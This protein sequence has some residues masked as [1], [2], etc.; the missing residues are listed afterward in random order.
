MIAMPQPSLT[1]GT[2]I[3]QLASS[4]ASRRASLTWPWKV[5]RSLTPSASA[6]ATS[7]ADHQ[8]EPITS[9]RRSGMAGCS[10]ASS[11]Q[12]VL[13]LLVR[14]QP[15]QHADPRGGRARLQPGRVRHVD[16]VADHRDPV[17]VDAEAGQVVPAGLRD[18]DV[19]LPAVEPGRQP[20]LHPPAD[21]AAHAG[22]DDLPLLA[23][24]VVHQH[25][26]V[27]AVHQRR[28][29]RDA[30]VDVDDD[31][32]APAGPAEQVG[33]A[34]G[35]RRRAGRP[36]GGTGRRRAPRRPGRWGARR[37]RWSPDGRGRPA[38]GPCARRRPPNRR[39]RGGGVAPHQEGDA[40]WRR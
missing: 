2:S 22:I 32:G 33:Q 27:P 16:A 19:G 24:H 21:P 39:R 6:A 35:G 11:C 38:S 10:R 8:P 14:H 34:R 13:D 4:S 28:R 20:G 37:S 1:E 40:A 29:E 26:Q 12:G 31:V 3:S 25:V 23:V 30:V 15:A 17:R 9:S 7:S 5:T 18:G 36:G